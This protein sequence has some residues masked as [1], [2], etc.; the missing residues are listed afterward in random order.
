MNRTN[1]HHLKRKIKSLMIVDDDGS[2]I[3]PDLTFYEQ[4]LALD[5]SICLDH[6]RKERERFKSEAERSLLRFQYDVESFALRL[7]KRGFSM[8]HVKLLILEHT[9]KALGFY[10]ELSPEDLR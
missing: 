8:Q 9:F 5:D 4:M 1:P 10:K 2:I 3:E 7:F 6:L